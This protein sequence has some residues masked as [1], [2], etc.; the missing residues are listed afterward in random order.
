MITK[1]LLTLLDKAENPRFV[2]MLDWA[3]QKS[4]GVSGSFSTVDWYQ[5]NG[6]NRIANFLGGSDSWSGKIINTESALDI[7]AFY[8]GVKVIAEDLGAL[9]FPTYQRSRDRKR[10]DKY[11]EHPLYTTLHDLWNPDVSAGEGVEALSAHAL[12]TGAGYAEIQRFD[13]GVFLWP[14]QPGETH[15]DKNA[16]GATVYINRASGR[17]KTYTREQVFHLKGFTLDGR[18]GENTVRRARH[19]LGIYA[20]ADEYAGRFFAQDAAPGVIINF[21]AGA[22]TIGP[23]SVIEIKKKWKEWHQ[24]AANAHEPAVLQNGA[25]VTRV[26]WNPQESQLLEIRK[27][28]LTEA[29]RILRIQ[30]H[31]L[32]DLTRSTNNNI[33]H[34]GIEYV[35]NTIGPWVDRWRRSV[36]RCLLTFDEQRAQRV[37]AEMDVQGLLRGDFTA[38]SEGWRK[39]LE[40]GV[41]S[42]NEVRAWL[43]LNPVEGGDNHFIQLNLATVQDVASGATLASDKTGTMPISGLTE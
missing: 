3:L 13:S 33:E 6:Y 11:Y 39:L 17:D 5:A 20:A 16:T 10:I 18:N 26:G 21:P 43:N 9:P 31:K 29:C 36:Y 25:T 40:K 14:W 22:P 41:Y 1:S 27:Y 38:Q 19:A 28:Q 7:P 2:R 30:P 42:I 15:T 4:T 12:I 23:E 32:M 35:V 34:Q 24:G 37:W 8:S